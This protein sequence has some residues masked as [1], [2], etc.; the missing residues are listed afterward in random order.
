[1]T[2]A[3]QH[4]AVCDIEELVRYCD[5][6]ATQQ[7]PLTLTMFPNSTPD[8]KEDEILWHISSFRDSFENNAEASFRKVC[9]NDNTPV[10][11][12]MWI[13]DQ[14]SLS[15]RN[16]G[17][18][19]KATTAA[20][21]PKS[22][23]VGAWRELSQRLAT[24]R[25]RALKDLT[26]VWSKFVFFL[27]CGCYLTRYAGLVTLS[28]SPT[29]QRQGCGS[30]LLAWG[31]AQADRNGRTSFVMASPAAGDLYERFGFMAV[32]EVV[33]PTGTFRSM[34]REPKL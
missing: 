28:V 9:A 7:N 29:H 33:S 12:A 4:V 1:M 17:S 18:Q 22:L 23:D 34:L 5:Y 21:L 16:S 6:P 10:G 32:G 3:L 20:Q 24:E 2:Y 8:T 14:N 31:C 19:S 25:R 11:F 27:L 26:N 13:L 15:I 30:M